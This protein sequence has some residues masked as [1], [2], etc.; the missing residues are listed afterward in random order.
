MPSLIQYDAARRYGENVLKK[1]FF[2]WYFVKVREFRVVYLFRKRHHHKTEN[3]RIRHLLWDV[4]N[5]WLGNNI[6]IDDDA[7]IGQGLRILHAFGIAIGPAEIGK[8]CTI[9]QNVTIGP[10]YEKRDSTGNRDPII[11]DNVIITLGA[12]ILGP[13]HIGSNVV[14]G[15]NSVVVSDFP[16]N[17]V[18]AGAPARIIGKYDKSRFG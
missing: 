12:V 5:R 3:H 7:V 9:S 15:A 13:V 4:L 17:C 11:G 10:N 8:N 16:D 6:Y 1:R 2:F 18:I 14:I